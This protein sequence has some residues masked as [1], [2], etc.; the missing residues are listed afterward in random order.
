MASARITLRLHMHIRTHTG[1]CHQQETDGQGSLLR[2]AAPHDRLQSPGVNRSARTLVLLIGRSP[3]RLAYIFARHFKIVWH[4]D[5]P[6][7][8]P[9]GHKGAY[10]T[11]F[12]Y[13]LEF[14]FLFFTK[15]FVQF[16]YY[17]IYAYTLS[18]IYYQVEQPWPE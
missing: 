12:D 10:C 6:Q 14:M 8:W 16:F 5:G 7:N 2:E 18:T 17:L 4:L 15:I 13:I 11:L 3:S 9:L 1:T